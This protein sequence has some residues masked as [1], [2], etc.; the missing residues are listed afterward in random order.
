MRAAR[1]RL[2]RMEAAQVQRLYRQTAAEFG[3]DPEALMEEGELFFAMSLDEQ[4]AEVDHL[5]PEL[6]AEGI[7]N[8]A[9][10]DDIRATLWEH[11]RS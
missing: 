2:E 8:A 5:A 1:R 10:I 3:L 4:L 11:Y 7:C 9:E 6:I